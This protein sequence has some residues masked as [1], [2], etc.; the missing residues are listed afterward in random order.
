[1]KLQKGKIVLEISSYCSENYVNTKQQILN[2]CKK[3]QEEQ[4]ELKTPKQKYVWIKIG[5]QE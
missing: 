2:L 4:D 3:I 1:M 5:M